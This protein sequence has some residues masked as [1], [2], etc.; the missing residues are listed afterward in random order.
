MAGV[1]QVTPG[2]LTN[3]WQ[4][5]RAQQPQTGLLASKWVV[6]TSLYTAST[7]VTMT[8]LLG[9]E[10]WGMGRREASLETGKHGLPISTYQETQPWRL[11]EH[12]GNAPKGPLPSQIC[13]PLG[14][15]PFGPLRGRRGLPRSLLASHRF[16][17]SREREAQ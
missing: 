12:L 15:I 7:P 5:L 14:R 13:S 11:K 10:T 3:E 1:A 9:D 4:G 16:H 2:G 6:G 17:A 8:G